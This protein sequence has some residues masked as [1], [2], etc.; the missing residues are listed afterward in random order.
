MVEDEEMVRQLVCECLAASGYEV[1]SARDPKEGLRLASKRRKT[2]HLLL[3]DVIMP[4]MNG[5]KLYGELS[6]IHPE[7]K[8]LYMSGYT[9]N[10]IAAHGLLEEDVEF[11]QKP[12]TVKGLAQKVRQVVDRAMRRPRMRT[13]HKRLHL[14]DL[15]GWFYLWPAF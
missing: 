8:V 4:V 5:R 13:E 7:T 2:L 1:L 6:A 14:M 9:D 3:T 10:V 15:R 12:F 11:L